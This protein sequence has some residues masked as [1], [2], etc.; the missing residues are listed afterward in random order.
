MRRIVKNNEPAI[1]SEFKK[2]YKNKNHNAAQYD[3]L[4]AEARTLVKGY[5]ITEQYGICAYCMSAIKNEA[6]HIEHIKPQS[7]FPGLSLE[8]SNLVASCESD[9]SCGK[10]KGNKY[11]GAFVAPTEA[12]C[13]AQYS[14]AMDGRIIPLTDRANYTIKL[15]NLNSYKLKTARKT[16]IISSGIYNKD[17]DSIRKLISDYYSHPNTEGCLPAFCMAVAWAIENH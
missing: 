17:F 9:N 15:L 5:L 3:D 6:C 16:A 13:E 10:H 11:D 1:I 7:K 14:Y 8:Y 12:D 4:T 2:R